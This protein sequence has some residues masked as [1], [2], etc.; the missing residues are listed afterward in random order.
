MVVVHSKSTLDE[1]QDDIKSL[2]KFT[3]TTKKLIIKFHKENKERYV[4]NMGNTYTARNF[5]VAGKNE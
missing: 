5:S 3:G 4:E 1:L 2:I